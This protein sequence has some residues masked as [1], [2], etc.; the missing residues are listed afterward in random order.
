[1]TMRKKLSEGEVKRHLIADAEETDAWEAPIVVPPSQSPRPSWY[2]RSKHLELAAKFLVLS[3]LHR[4]GAEASL[5]HVPTDDV[6]I[7]AV[8]QSGEVFTIDVKTLSGS[9]EWTIQNLGASK[10]HFVV[11][12]S[13]PRDWSDP[14][15]A[16]D[17]YIWDSELLRS[18]IARQ[19]AKT[20]SLEAIASKLDPTAAWERLATSPAA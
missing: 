6:D 10:H 4:L 16:P 9:S 20:I 8:R 11:F 14:R 15:I 2:G 1:M 12:V 3:I 18:F 13:F 19:K 17:V 5:T 7:A